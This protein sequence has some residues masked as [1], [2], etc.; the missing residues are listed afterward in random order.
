[1]DSGNSDSFQSSN[2]GDE[3]YNS[4][5]GGGGG[6]DGNTISTFTAAT[7]GGG[8]IYNLPPHQPTNQPMFDPIISNYQNLQNNMLLNNNNLDMVWSKTLR[9]D[10]SCTETSNPLSSQQQFIIQNS[11]LPSSSSSVPE[12]MNTN[13]SRTSSLPLSDHHQT[14]G[15]ASVRNPNP[16]K[17]SRASR[18]APTT[19]LATDTTNFRAMVQEFTGIPEPPF[20]SSSSSLF[21]R[22][23]RLDNLFAT[24]SSMRS[25]PLDYPI[26]LSSQPPPYIRPSPQKLQPPMFGA[27]MLDSLRTNV[28]DSYQC[29]QSSNLFTMQNP[30]LASLLQSKP[31]NPTFSDNPSIFESKTHH[32]S[33]QIQSSNRV[34]DEFGGLRQGLV[35]NNVSLDALPGLV[36]AYPTRCGVGAGG[37]TEGGGDQVRSFG[38][39]NKSSDDFSRN[40]P[41]AKRLREMMEDGARSEGMMET[42]NCSSSES[43]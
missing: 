31:P 17:R 2:G 10:P 19:V 40:I 12:I 39:N 30:I 43:K 35:D 9:S 42:W 1:M 28:D 23:S 13:N 37:A 36:S 15:L 32:G 16:K 21:S 8:L 22:N 14:H 4:H 34:M 5:G 3:E 29:L 41:N 33:M 38:N 27:S 6:G 25:T 24:S 20:T 26:S 11:N 18:R 7:R